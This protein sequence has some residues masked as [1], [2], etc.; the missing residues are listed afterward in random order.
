[1]FPPFRPSFG[2]VS[3]QGLLSPTIWLLQGDPTS[4]PLSL[5]S[6]STVPPLTTSGLVVVT[7]LALCQSMGAST[8]CVR[9]PNP[10]LPLLKWSLSKDCLFKSSESSEVSFLLGFWLIHYFCN[11]ALLALRAN[12]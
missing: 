8:S 2:N 3:F 9:S 5:G 1:M 11:L 12:S 10:A 6:D 4:A 7:A